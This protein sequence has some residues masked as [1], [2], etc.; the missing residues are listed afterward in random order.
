MTPH[1]SRLTPHAARRRS[2]IG[3][4]RPL[5]SALVRNFSK[6]S[7]RDGMAVGRLWPCR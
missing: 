5:D 6:I 1:A 7:G 3:F 4:V 2:E